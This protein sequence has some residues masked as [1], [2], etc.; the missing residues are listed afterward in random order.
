M[1]KLKDIYTHKSLLSIYVYNYVI[2]IMFLC[3]IF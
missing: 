3:V 2:Y 1:K